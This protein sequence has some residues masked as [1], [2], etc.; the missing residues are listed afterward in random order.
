MACCPSLSYTAIPSYR[1]QQNYFFNIGTICLTKPEGSIAET[2]KGALK[3]T[4]RFCYSIH[5]NYSV[6]LRIL[7]L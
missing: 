4:S 2:E 5:L 6:E 1:G 3:A 7:R